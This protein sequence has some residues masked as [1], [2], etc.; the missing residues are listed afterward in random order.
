MLRRHSGRFALL[1]KRAWPRMEEEM[2]EIRK[3]GQRK[4]LEWTLDYLILLSNKQ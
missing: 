4:A 2:R 1:Q 3:P